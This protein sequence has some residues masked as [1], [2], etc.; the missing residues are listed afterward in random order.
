[1][2]HSVQYLIITGSFDG[3]ESDFFLCFNGPPKPANE[4]KLSIFFEWGGVMYICIYV[5]VN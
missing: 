4:I 1:M 5:S 3:Y 2:D